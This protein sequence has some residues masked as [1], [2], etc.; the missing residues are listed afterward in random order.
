MPDCFRGETKE[1]NS[2]IVKWLKKYPIEIVMKDIKSCQKHIEMKYCNSDRNH[3][4]EA[5]EYSSIGFCWGGWA[6][7]KSKAEGMNW[8]CAVSPHPS[9]K[10]EN[11]IFGND[12]KIMLD[13]IDMP[14]LL[15]PAGNDRENLKPGSKEVEK[16]KQ[17]GGKSILFEKMIHGWVTRGDLNEANVQEN[18]EKALM[19]SLEFIN[20]HNN[21][22]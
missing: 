10:I 19:L 8:K 4:G 2:D 22:R 12:E 14:F 15:L 3:N 7:A 17:Y 11:V 1:S 6:I 16:L 18:V 21:E 13:K 20:E 9:T 5:F